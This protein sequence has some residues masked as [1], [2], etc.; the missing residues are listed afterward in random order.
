MLFYLFKNNNSSEL[1]PWTNSDLQQVNNNNK[2]E[3]IKFKFKFLV[4]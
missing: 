1:V 2:K 3:V 4:R